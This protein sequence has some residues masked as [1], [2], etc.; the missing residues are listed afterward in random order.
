MRD[1]LRGLLAEIVVGPAK[2]R[3][4]WLGDQ[5]RILD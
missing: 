3:L 4:P 1:R 2:A 5:L